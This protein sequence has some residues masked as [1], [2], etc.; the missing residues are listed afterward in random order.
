MAKVKFVRKNF[1]SAQKS[2]GVLTLS[3]NGEP[4]NGNFIIE[5]LR[6][7]RNKAT[8][9]TKTMLIAGWFG[10]VELWGV[11]E[12]SSFLPLFKGAEELELDF[13]TQ[14]I[15]MQDGLPSA[16]VDRV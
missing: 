8:S 12:R 9:V 11:L 10:A 3:V 6:P 4:I 5:N 1:Q 7:S 2:D 14:C 16:I 15:A 13:D